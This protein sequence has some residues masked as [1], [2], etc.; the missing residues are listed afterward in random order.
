METWKLGAHLRHTCDVLLG[1][2]QSTF[3]L[4]ETVEILDPIG[5]H[6]ASYP[7]LALSRRIGADYGDVLWFADYLTN[8]DL[9]MHS[10]FH[11]NQ[12]YRD[13][14][15]RLTHEQREAILARV[16]ELRSQA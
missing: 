7:F 3:Y 2:C 5:E 16:N 6:S 8:S 4:E 11:P 15:D 10:S 12:H 14:L 13:A 1:E 9:N